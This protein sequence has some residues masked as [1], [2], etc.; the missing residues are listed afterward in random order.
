MIIDIGFKFKFITPTCTLYVAIQS[1]TRACRLAVDP[2]GDTHKTSLQVVNGK[3]WCVNK[4]ALVY[5]HTTLKT[6]KLSNCN[7]GPG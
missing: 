1:S 7:V 3:T 4:L 2:D 6:P 5:G